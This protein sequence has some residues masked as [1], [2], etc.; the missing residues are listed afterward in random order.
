MSM[1]EDLQYLQVESFTDFMRNFASWLYVGFLYCFMNWCVAAVVV[2]NV[3]EIFSSLANFKNN[4][5]KFTRLFFCGIVKRAT[6][7]DISVEENVRPDHHWQ[8][9]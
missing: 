1:E 5:T 3:V 2:L 9:S 6:S 7:V 4:S 8:V